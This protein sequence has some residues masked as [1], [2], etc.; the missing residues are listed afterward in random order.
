MSSAFLQV[1]LDRRVQQG[2]SSPSPLPRISAARLRPD[3]FQQAFEEEATKEKP[4]ETKRY[5]SRLYVHEQTLYLQVVA[6]KVSEHVNSPWGSLP[7]A[8]LR[9]LGTSLLIQS[10]VLIHSRSSKF[11]VRVQRILLWRIQVCN[12]KGAV[13]MVLEAG[14]PNAEGFRKVTKVTVLVK[15]KEGLSDEDFMDHYNNVHAQMAVPVLLRHNV[16]TYSLVRR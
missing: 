9:Y 5:L 10:N 11:L 16:I 12:S 13:K 4:V 14:Y 6:S 15:K 3:D 7:P 2:E 8:C 1:T